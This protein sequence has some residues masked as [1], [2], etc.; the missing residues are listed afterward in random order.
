MYRGDKIV[1]PVDII[2]DK[3]ARKVSDIKDNE[4]GYDIGNET[5]K[6]FSDILKDAK[7]CII[8]GANFEGS[9]NCM[10]DVSQVSQR[11]LT[12]AN[13]GSAM[14]SGSFY[15]CNTQN[16][17][18]TN[19]TYEKELITDEKEFKMSVHRKIRERNK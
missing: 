2:T 17:K 15:G 1:L 19:A 3:C 6:I 14:L 12:N 16:T 9:G 11:M 4:C 7:R 13:L 18:F 10:I 8:M 5:I